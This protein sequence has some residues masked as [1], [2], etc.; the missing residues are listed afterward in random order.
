MA[1]G[2]DVFMPLRLSESQFPLQVQRVSIFNRINKINNGLFAFA[3][4]DIVNLGFS[5][6]YFLQ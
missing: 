3:A 2:W 6:Q 1:D 5:F 4:Y